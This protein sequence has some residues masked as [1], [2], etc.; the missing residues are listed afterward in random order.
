M[1]KSGET[2]PGAL[3]FLERRRGRDKTEIDLAAPSLL[4]VL[5][6]SLL[7]LPCA[8]MLKTGSLGPH[9]GVIYVP[10]LTMLMGMPASVATATSTATMLISNAAA[11]LIRMGD[12]LWDVVILVGGGSVTSAMVVP[13]FVSGKLKSEVL[14]AGFWTATMGAATITLVRALIA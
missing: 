6:H 3:H 8:L 11:M 4:N 7:H 14:L 1:P 5:A 9:A 13:R 10:V 2:H 12:V